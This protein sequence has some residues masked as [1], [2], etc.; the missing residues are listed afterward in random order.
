MVTSSRRPSVTRG[1]RGEV[2]AVG[3]KLRQVGPIALASG[4][5]FWQVFRDATVVRAEGY[6]SG[7]NARDMNE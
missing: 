6:H 5:V 4:P 3:A 7:R 2:S 1:G